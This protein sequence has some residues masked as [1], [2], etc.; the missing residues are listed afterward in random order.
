MAP[1]AVE[2]ARAEGG[3]GEGGAVERYRVKAGETLLQIA[4]RFTPPGTTTYQTALALYRHNRHA[5]LDDNP[6]LIRAGALLEIPDRQAVQEIPPEEARREFQRSLAA[7]RERQKTQLA[8]RETPSTPRPE[9]YPPPATPRLKLEV[10]PGEPE[11]VSREEAPSSREAGLILALQRRVAALERQLERADEE[12]AVAVLETLYRELK[13]PRAKTSKPVVVAQKEP[14]KP[15]EPPQGELF[16]ETAETITTYRP[17]LLTFSFLLLTFAGFLAFQRARRRREV[18][19]IMTTP[20]AAVAAMTQ[21]ELPAEAHEEAPTES[22]SERE[23]AQSVATTSQEEE[24]PAEPEIDWLKDFELDE[25][26]ALDFDLTG[27]GEMEV[28]DPLTEAD[29]YLT[30]FQ[31]DKAEEIIR[32][33]LE[34]EPNRTDLQFKLLEI[35]YHKADPTSFEQYAKRFAEQGLARDPA[36]WAR[37]VEMG[38]ALC[39]TSDFF[40]EATP[41]EEKPPVEEA[42]TG[43]PVR[44]TPPKI[45]ESPEEPHASESDEGTP[46]PEKPA[47]ETDL[48]PSLGEP[49]RFTPPKIEESPEERHAPEEEPLRFQGEEAHRGPSPLEPS[50]KEDVADGGNGASVWDRESRV[51][52]EV[53]KTYLQLGRRNEARAILEEL[54]LHGSEAVRS[55]VRELLE[56]LEEE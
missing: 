56:S 48:E 37:V 23:V 41:L 46:P 5:F 3:A 30:Y 49:V 10:P 47:V 38:R 20:Q 36:I 4:R 39:P 40:K 33:A 25:K 22:V 9:G 44:F 2:P 29:V 24:A 27:E 42:D 1:S 53:A 21:E 45:E 19:E 15:E 32:K 18:E 26:L 14:E 35:Y 16:S 43:E 17:Y 55:E 50:L 6:N 31:Y 54:Y 34:E 52:L 8:K 7:W 51:R 12:L 11:T 13:P 28:I